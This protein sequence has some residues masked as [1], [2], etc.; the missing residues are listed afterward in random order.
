MQ[1]DFFLEYLDYT[2][3]SEV[4]RFFDRWCAISMLGAWLERD[5]Y[6][7]FGR[8]KLYPNMYTLLM[9]AAGTKKSTAIKAAKNLL[10]NAGYKTFSA[11]KTSKEKFLAD[12]GDGVDIG[13]GES[14]LEQDLFGSDSFDS[15]PCWIAADEFNDFF[16]NNVLEFV[17]MLGALWDWDGPY[18]NKVKNGK[19]VTI[20]NPII[21]L[22][23]GTTQTQFAETFPPSAVGQGFFSRVLV[24]YARPT[25]EKITWPPL[26]DEEWT[27]RMVSRLHEIKAKVVGELEYSPEAKVLIDKIYKTWHDVRFAAYSNRRLTHLLKVSMLHAAARM[28][29]IIEAVDVRHAN[30]VMYHAEQFMPDAFGDFGFSRTSTLVHKVSQILE[31]SDGMDMQDLWAKVQSDFDKLDT[32]HQTVAGMI[33]AGKVKTHEH[34]LYPVRRAVK[35]KYNDMVDYNYLIEGE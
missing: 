19:S 22:L 3:G 10:R 5:I 18:E 28:S 16:G 7:K 34:K 13:D 17:S 35:E 30:T 9:G 8:S 24:I 20:P 1:D 31:A 21:S 25:G 33:H 29:N 32:F 12:L 14:F 11:E 23:G 27:E 6:C 26:E 15:R 2:A 4:P